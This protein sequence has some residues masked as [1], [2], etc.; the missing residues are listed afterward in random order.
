MKFKIIE[1]GEI[2]EIIINDSKHDIEIT[3]DFM[4]NHDAL[5]VNS[6]DEYELYAEDYEWWSNIADQH[7]ANNQIIRELL[8][9]GIDS[10]KINEILSD[11]ADFDLDEQVKGIEKSLNELKQVDSCPDCGYIHDG[12]PCHCWRTEN[13][14]Y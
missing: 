10:D 9:M 12:E 6:K 2:K 7:N 13:P 1:T 3:Q 14:E 5:Y 8:D 11:W 4:A